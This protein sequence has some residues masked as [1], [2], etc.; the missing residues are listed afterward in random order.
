VQPRLPEQLLQ[1]LLLCC[2]RGCCCCRRRLSSGRGCGL[3]GHKQGHIVLQVVVRE[4]E[5]VEGH[6]GE[7]CGAPEGGAA[8]CAAVGALQEGALV[9]VRQETW[10]GVRQWR[11]LRRWIKELGMRPWKH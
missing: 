11:W 2:C 4:V 8:V 3:E 5:G 7:G 9:P 6:G 1:V 10:C